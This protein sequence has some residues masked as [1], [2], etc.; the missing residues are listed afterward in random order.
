MAENKRIKEFTRILT[1]TVLL[2]G[3]GLIVENFS[4]KLPSTGILT[5]LALVIMAFAGFVHLKYSETMT[6]LYNLNPFGPRTTS[7]GNKTF[8]LVLLIITGVYCS[9]LLILAVI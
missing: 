1:L 3:L 4:D 7:K 5:P 8:G 2:F 9:G 6:Y